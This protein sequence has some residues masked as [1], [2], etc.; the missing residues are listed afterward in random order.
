MSN[1]DS[2]LT[3]CVHCGKCGGHA[4]GCLILRIASLE[5]DIAEAQAETAMRHQLFIDE[6]Q[7]S[8]ESREAR[9]SL[10][11]DRLRA[12]K[13]AHELTLETQTCEEAVAD[14]VRQVKEARAKIDERNLTLLGEVNKKLD[15]EHSLRDEREAHEATRAEL[16]RLKGIDC[17]YA[18]KADAADILSRDADGLAKALAASQAAHL[19]T[20]ELGEAMWHGIQ[21]VVS[22]NDEEEWF[23][24]YAPASAWRAANPKKGG[25]T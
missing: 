3:G 12:L 5:C 18:F 22:R 14:L 17:A 16:E 6:E 7:T 21:Y 25:G 2:Y 4:V 13:L 8:A 15:A 24:I 23:D 9:K 19:C 11:D 1:E 10:E 20:V